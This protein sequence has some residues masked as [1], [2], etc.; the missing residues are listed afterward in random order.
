MVKYLV[1]AG[2]GRQGMATVKAL[3]DDGQEVYATSRNPSGSGAR[4]LIGYGVKKVLPAS[5]GDVE[6]LQA[7]IRES[8]ATRVWFMTDYYS[9]GLTFASRA[10]EV[11]Q[12]QSVIDAIKN[13][14][15]QVEFVV[16]SSVGDAD[17]CPE[18]VHHFHSKADI[19]RALAEQLPSTCRWAVLRPVAFLE[20][21]DDPANYN[22]LNRGHVKFLTK[23]PETSVKFIATDDIGK[24]SCKMLMDPEKFA[25][26]IIEAAGCEHTGRELAQI[27][28]EVS[29]HP[30]QY[31]PSMPRW[32]MWLLPPLWDLYAMVSFFEDTGYS[33]DV[34]AFRELVPDAMDAKDWFKAKGQWADG[35]AFVGEK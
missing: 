15:P 4:R 18:S 13:C 14:G 29:G 27:L 5:Y 7:A 16:F 12:G 19:E 22:P 34:D 24:A 31:S 3:L 8:G 23:S 17:A 6:S 32:V 1:I 2:T 21:L 10:K 30:C 33:A 28:S 9:G 25:G 35:G 11:A 20:N 26:K